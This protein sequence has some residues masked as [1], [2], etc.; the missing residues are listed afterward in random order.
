M[1]KQEEYLQVKEA[2]E[3]LGVCPNT[4]RNW[5]KV[6]K[7]DEYRHPLNGYRMF[8]RSDLEALA[9]MLRAPSRTAATRKS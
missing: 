6:G 2:A 9:R 7:V 8:R 3:L 5:G 1:S 4:V